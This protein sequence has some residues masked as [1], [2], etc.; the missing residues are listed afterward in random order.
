M[1]RISP[2]LVF[3]LENAVAP[4]TFAVSGGQ[5]FYFDRI[6]KYE[7]RFCRLFNGCGYLEAEVDE[8]QGIIT[9]EGE[10]YLMKIDTNFTS[11]ER[12]LGQDRFQEVIRPEGI[13]FDIGK[14]ETGNFVCL[15]NLNSA[16]I[17]KIL[18]GSGRVLNDIWPENIIFGSSIC[19]QGEYIYLGAVDSCN[20]FRI[21]KLNYL[22]KVEESI[23]V[24]V[25]SED[26][27]IGRIYIYYDYIFILVAGKQSSLVILDRAK[28]SLKEIFPER[29]GISHIVDFRI[30]GDYVYI[31]DGRDIHVFECRNALQL[32][33][34]G[35]T[36]FRFSLESLYYRYH[37][38]SRGLR[39]QVSFSLF[40][41]A[42][43]VFP[44]SALLAARI[45][46]SIGRWGIFIISCC[47]YIITVYFA[48]MVKNIFTMGKKESRI[49]Y[50]LS[51]CK[52]LGINEKLKVPVFLGAA[53]F[54]IA[55]LDMY[56][57]WD[58][59]FPLLAFLL[60]GL[61][62]YG[63]EMLCAKKIRAMSRD[64]VVELLED[65]DMQIFEHI[66]GVVRKLKMENGQKLSIE[67]VLDKRIK[68]KYLDRWRDTRNYITGQ[69]I[70]LEIEDN[71]VLAHMDLSKR[72]IKY[73]CFSIIM[74]YVCYIKSLGGIR[75]IQVE[76]MNRQI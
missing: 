67:I 40:A 48:A 28:C 61:V 70:S 39:D 42:L 63:I 66:R 75:E 68:R 36:T 6:N 43:P 13:F 55:E 58:L 69:N 9:H 20:N 74:D 51:S 2:V 32:E 31:L 19:L 34:G 23:K 7:S 52:E 14:N 76:V 18:T 35:K 50:L 49:E 47:L 21:L 25:N 8:V 24:S 10:K 54:A 30:Y 65:E 5:I 60:T 38:Y 45:L 29:F 1:K 37:I 71:R 33:N 12:L 56:P 59:A 4:E 11:I 72:D 3:N 62:F 22:G 17:I 44:V 53:A 46:E 41:A 15:G 57:K 16:T 27:I 64:M 73:S 26:R